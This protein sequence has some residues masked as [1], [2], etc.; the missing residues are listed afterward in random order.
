MNN[1]V[2]FVDSDCDITP[3]DCKKYGMQLISMPYTINDKEIF[4]YEDFKEFDC[5][6]FYDV[7]RKGVVPKT[8]ANSPVKYAEYFEP[9]LKEGKDI[10]YVH[11]SKTMS[12]TFNAM[13]IAIEDLKEKYPERTIYTLDTKAITIL[14]RN[15]VLDIGEMYAKGAT[16]EDIYK[17]AETEIYHYAVY[18]YADDLKFF[19]KSGRVSNFAAFMG[20]MINL[21]PII[22]INDE[23]QMVAAS[24]GLG[25]NT[26]LKKIVDTVKNLED[27]IKDHR[28]LIAHS[29][30]IELAKKAQEMLEA[31]FGKLP[32]EFV[33]VN[34]TAGSHCGPD[35]I[36]ISFHSKHR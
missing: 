17:W 19:S 8:S 36:G 25:R 24:K 7:L 11:F 30:N 1:F 28:V 23:G 2:L 5:H 33:E 6:K 13:N 4:P 22:Y 14:S 31:E 10:L 21:K 12:G 35:A 34:P 18:F 3:V 16:I 20:G 29:D 9:F 15:I 26:T 32:I 27:N